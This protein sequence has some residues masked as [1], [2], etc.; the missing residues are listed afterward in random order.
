MHGTTVAGNEHIA[1]VDD[2]G[3]NRKLLWRHNEQF[4][5]RGAWQRGNDS[6]FDFYI[7]MPA[8]NQNRINIFGFQQTFYYLNLQRE[9]YLGV[10]AGSVRIQEH[11]PLSMSEILSLQEIFCPLD[12]IMRQIYDVSFERRGRLVIVPSGGGVA[13]TGDCD[14]G[15]ELLEEN[16]QHRRDVFRS[17]VQPP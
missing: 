16:T 2:S 7:R 5:S 17:S 9:W 3:K 1:G 6:F 11:E 13:F 10:F 15:E 14:T 4:L 8:A 12:C